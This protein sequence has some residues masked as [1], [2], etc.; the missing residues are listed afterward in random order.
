MHCDSSWAVLFA[1]EIEPRLTC[2]AHRL[3]SILVDDWRVVLLPAGAHFLDGRQFQVAQ[4]LSEFYEFAV[5]R[6]QGFW[7]FNFFPFSCH[8]NS[9]FMAGFALQAQPWS[10]PFD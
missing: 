1:A 6:R 9:P 3:D 10:I 2:A 5:R 8:F 4:R 7:L